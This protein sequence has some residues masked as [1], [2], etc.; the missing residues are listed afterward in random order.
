MILDVLG[1]GK[2]IKTVIYGFFISMDAVVYYF[3][4]LWYRLFILLATI[5]IF[6][7]DDYNALV[8]R[9]YIILG[10]IMLFIL[11]YSM[12]KAIVDPDGTEKSDDAPAKI[13]GK[14]VTSLILVIVMPVIFEYAYG[15]Q[16]AILKNNTL[17]KIILGSPGGLEEIGRASCRE[18]V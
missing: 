9:I 14:T 3:V 1:I 10:V 5:N 13:V 17:G 12:L 18:R 16:I 11:S 8:D 15:F 2:A 4:S 7:V 6:D